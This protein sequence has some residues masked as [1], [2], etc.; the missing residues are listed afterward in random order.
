MGLLDRITGFL[1]FGRSG[2]AGTDEDGGGRTRTKSS[3]ISVSFDEDG[4][5]T[6][7]HATETQALAWG[8]V[9]GIFIITTSVGPFRTETFW[10]FAADQVELILSVPADA[11]GLE[12]LAAELPRHFGGIDFGALE[13]GGAKDPVILLWGDIPEVD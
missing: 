12:A 2:G 11:E 4:L 1:R 8:A 13:D 5:S 7:Y 6:T 10:C 9:S 3:A